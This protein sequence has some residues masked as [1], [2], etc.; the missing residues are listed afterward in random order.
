MPTAER[1][2]FIAYDTRLLQPKPGE[3]PESALNRA[4]D[5][6][7]GFVLEQKNAP[8]KERVNCL[9]LR[10]TQDGKLFNPDT[11]EVIE[12][13]LRNQAETDGPENKVFDKIQN[14]LFGNETGLAV[15]ISPPKEGFFEESRIL[16]YAIQKE[17]G[18]KI[19]RLWALPSKNNGEGCVEAAN[20]L[21]GFS[22]ENPKTIKDP[23]ELRCAPIFIQ[24]PVNLNLDKFLSEFFYF[25]KGT[26]EKLQTGEYIKIRQAAQR[27][28]C[29]VINTWGNRLLTAQTSREHIWIGAKVEE[30]MAKRGYSLRSSGPCGILNSALLGLSAG[31]F[32]RLYAQVSHEGKFV[33]KCGLCNREIKKHIPAGYKCPSCGGIYLGC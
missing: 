22:L 6:L 13:G 11:G 9:T 5:H 18:D 7:T 26:L 17:G 15:W 29:E 25:P 19:V 20:C 2:K 1:K 27:E 10:F 24:G 12:N 8:P 14:W 16:L 33:H 31:I 28:A 21:L 3:T 23:E 30:E 32:D 4:V